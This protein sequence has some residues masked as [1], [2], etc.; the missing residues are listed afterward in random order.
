MAK[1]E[2]IS[3]CVYARTP[4]II[5][6]IREASR[7]LEDEFRV[8][9]PEIFNLLPAAVDFLNYGQS[10]YRLFIAEYD[11]NDPIINK[12]I[13]DIH[14]DPWLHGTITI[15]I[16][17]EL[18]KD[19]FE[20]LVNHGVTDFVP[21]SEFRHKF[22][23]IMKIISSNLDLFESQQFLSLYSTRKKGKIHLKTA[24]SV[25][26]RASNILLNFCYQTGMRNLSLYSKI[27]LC[28]YE[29]IG[30]AVEHGN[31]G[32]DYDDKTRLLEED[33]NL[34]DYI[35]EISAQPENREKKITITYDISETKAVISIKDEGPGFDVST[36]PD[37]KD[38]ENIF[39]SHGRGIMLARSYADELTYN[40][41]GNEV[42]LVFSN[43]DNLFKRQNE[44]QQLTNEPVLTLEPG[45]I[46]FE[47]NSESNYFYFIISGK[48]GIYVK[49]KQVAISTPEDI[50][51]GEMAFLHHNKR[52]GTVKALSKSELLPIS[53]NGF[54]N[55]IKKYPYAGVF[56][57]RLLTK[58]LV[59]KNRGID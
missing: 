50:F 13:E 42:T 24:L 19:Q 43:A 5:E 45:E 49:G 12:T 21:V 35:D 7:G 1:K 10:T 40:E 36:I 56:L 3:F 23:I 11:N 26:P 38:E 53:R 55:M 52:T 34:Y 58:R 44:L 8:F 57:A 14:N 18:N 2:K 17:N 27:S 51:V 39:A 9:E 48:L 4:E 46:L 59:E 47:D 37:P 54:I 25:V 6:S 32:I 28:M 22:P 29:M 30:N 31:L 33:K 41:T 15:L 20:Y 16:S